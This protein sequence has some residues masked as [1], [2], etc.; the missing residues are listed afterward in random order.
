MKKTPIKLL[1]LK[2]RILAVIDEETKKIIV[3]EILRGKSPI[4]IVIEYGIPPDEVE[5][6]YKEIYNLPKK[7]SSM[8]LDIPEDM[9]ALFMVA[10]V[11]TTLDIITTRVALLHPYTYEVNP[12]MRTL[13]S[14]VGVEYTLLV[15]II[16]S[17]IGI[18]ALTVF[19]AKYLKGYSRYVPL[20]LYC[21]LRLIPVVKNYKI[22]LSLFS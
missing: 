6:I 1:Y 19:S 12:I 14:F 13:M 21:A 10:L 5:K 9:I 15:N 18:I 20:V 8:N 11:I 17:S 3:Q 2:I 22:L 16:L 7:E 4:D